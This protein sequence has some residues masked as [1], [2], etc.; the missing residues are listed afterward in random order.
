MKEEQ[1]DVNKREVQTGE[2]RATKRIVEET[3]SVEVPV[4]HEEVVIDRHKLTNGSNSDGIAEDDKII[5]PISEEQIEITKHPVV[6]EE[7]S[8]NK[9]EVEDTK[10][11]SETVRKEDIYVETEGN[12]HVKKEVSKK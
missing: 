6:K 12:I 5:I 10:Q 1:I 7:V 4:R 8:I 3:K 9:K 11:V 2:V